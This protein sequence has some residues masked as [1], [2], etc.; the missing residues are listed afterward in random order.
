VVI[1]EDFFLKIVRAQV[2]NLSSN[3]ATALNYTNAE[4]DSLKPGVAGG[5]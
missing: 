2:H 4:G 3:L 5:R 1:F